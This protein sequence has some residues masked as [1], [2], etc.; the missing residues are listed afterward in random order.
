MTDPA[1]DGAQPGSSLVATV[2]EAGSAEPAPGRAL[3]APGQSFRLAS[4]PNLRDVG[5]YAASDGCVVR[6]GL[7][8]RSDQPGAIAPGDLQRMATLGLKSDFDLRTAEEAAACPDE[9]PPGVRRVSLDV[10]ADAGRAGAATL[11]TLLQNPEQANAT[12]GGGRMERM[13]ERAYRAFVSLP[14][15][16]Q[17]YGQ[18]FASLADETLLPALFHCTAGKD[19]TGWAA[20]AL[21]TLLGVPKSAVMEDYLRSNEYVLPR[22]QK[23]IEEFVAAG[24]EPAI[25]AAFFGVKAEYLEAAFDEVE[26]RYGTIERY[27][28]EGLGIDTAR[29][30]TLRSLYLAP[31]D[32]ANDRANRS[33]AAAG[34]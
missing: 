11:E 12:L 26:K 1:P 14:S 3:R 22:Y 32:G 31:P 13:L 18:L 7:A 16:R 15:A 8:Y 21:L 19:R 25:P 27:A 10:F 24:G 29:Q 6:T 28:C 20:A 23:A 5:G 33:E 30:E 34:R 9:L 4:V 17:A 2:E